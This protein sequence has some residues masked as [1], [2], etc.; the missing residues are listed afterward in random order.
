M[1]FQNLLEPGRICHVAL[2]HTQHHTVFEHLRLSGRLIGPLTHRR[3]AR[4][5]DLVQ[6]PAAGTVVMV[7]T[8][9]GVADLLQFPQLGIDLT[10]RRAPVEVADAPVGPLLDVVA[11]NLFLVGQHAE[12]RPARGSKI[13]FAGRTDCCHRSRVATA[14]SGYGAPG[15]LSGTTVAVSTSLIWMS[16]NGSRSAR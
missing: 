4:R 9:G 7:H 11:G 2:H 1:S 3:H 10:E 16:R 14:D 8:R 5:G 6:S 15:P 13:R 12:D